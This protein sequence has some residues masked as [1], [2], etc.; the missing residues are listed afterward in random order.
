MNI[1][2]PS[3]SLSATGAT[4]EYSSLADSGNEVKRRFVPSVVATYLPI[5]QR[6]HNLRLYVLAP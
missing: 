3:D 4:Q 2:V 1:I 6:A 5:L